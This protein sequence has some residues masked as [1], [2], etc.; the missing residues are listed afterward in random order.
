MSYAVTSN[1][2]RKIKRKLGIRGK[3]VIAIAALLACGLIA[4][5]VAIRGYARVDTT[6]EKITGRSIPAMNEAQVLALQ[7]ER[8]VSLAPLLTA[9]DTPEARDGIA[10]RIKEATAEYT[11][12]LSAIGTHGW[13]G[14]GF[15]DLESTS[16][17]LLAN[18]TELDS[19][20]VRRLQLAALRASLEKT[21]FEAEKLVID[22]LTPYK[23]NLKGGQEDEMNTLRASDDP[24]ELSASAQKMVDI[25]EKM[26]KADQI[27]ER[28][29]DARSWLVIAAGA[30]DEKQL[31]TA[32]SRAGLRL[33][34]VPTLQSTLPSDVEKVV[35]DPIAKLNA[36]N[37]GK[38]GMIATRKEELAILARA[39]DLVASNSALSAKLSTAVVG[40]VQQQET[41][42][43]QVSVQT[44]DLLAASRGMQVMVSVAGI[45][46]SILVAVLYVGKVVVNRLIAL[47]DAMEKIA[48]GN[49]DTE[50]KLAGNDEIA[51]MGGALIVFRD[52]AREVEEARSRADAERAKAAEDRRKAMLA[53]AD[54]FEASVKQVVHRVSD[55]ASQMHSIA[56][57]MTQTA[58]DTSRQAGS[59]ATAAETASHNVDNAAAAAVQ[60]KASIAEIAR[61]AADAAE[62][63]GRASTDAQHADNTVRTLD[64]AVGRIDSVLDLITS[65]A[66]QTNLLALN[67]T[68]E[69]ARAGDAG[70]GF[71]VVASEVK[72]L[73]SQ[74]AE[75]T[76]QIESQ[77]ASV[78]KVTSEA[79]TAIRNIAETVMTI[80]EIAAAIAAAVEE[81][82]SATAEIARHVTEAAD[83]TST[84][85]ENMGK[86]RSA[87]E[88]TGRSAEDVLNAAGMMASEADR[89][90]KQVDRFLSEVRAG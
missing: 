19:A 26:V 34:E 40:L 13:A 63:A 56:H 54:S 82:D 3:M 6:I 15:G 79:V 62:I 9:A 39:K 47:K 58:G 76:E 31:S 42:I 12:Q 2:G 24:K 61:R 90:M 35:K 57:H 88:T 37:S 29:T 50:V 77:I 73:A 65:I 80:D 69:A 89:L 25:G 81:Q 14:S 7:A 66:G 70:R 1:D 46:I 84:A 20:I 36:A 21:V 75:A 51:E 5:V 86:V 72:H 10:Q 53:I 22:T 4:S 59:A 17:A 41:E 28:I 32:R 60:L 44:V 67:A 68:I 71:A 85:S 23:S 55:A 11:A 74:T 48:E 30:T 27:A 83:G 16:K 52:T 33:S 87:A 45:I 8:L 43:K 38:E 49:L 64:E 78:H 18:L